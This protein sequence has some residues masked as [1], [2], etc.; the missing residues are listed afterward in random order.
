MFIELRWSPDSFRDE[1]RPGNRKKK[2]FCGSSR[3]TDR[4]TWNNWR[5]KSR[6]NKLRYEGEGWDKLMPRAFHQINVAPTLIKAKSLYRMSCGD[7][8]K[9]R[10]KRDVPTRENASSW[11]S[12][13]ND[14]CLRNNEPPCPYS[15][16][17]IHDTKRKILAMTGKVTL[18]QGVHIHT[19]IYTHIQRQLSSS[20]NRTARFDDSKSGK[21]FEAARSAGINSLS[22]LRASATR[23]VPFLWRTTVIDE[24]SSSRNDGMYRTKERASLSPPHPRPYPSIIHVDNLTC[25]RLR[26]KSCSLVIESATVGWLFP[27]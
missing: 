22:K 16:R 10:I 7:G 12:A 20:R 3:S 11:L 9:R 15:Q 6:A 5:A 18:A 26:G 23:F 24:P 19:H 4:R 14:A 2:F 25:R 8:K 1:R 21:Q 13:L 27:V 17:H